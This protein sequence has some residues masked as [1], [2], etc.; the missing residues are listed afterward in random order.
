[1]PEASWCTGNITSCNLFRSG[2]QA[3]LGIALIYQPGMYL[4]ASVFSG[5]T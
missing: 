3:A 5:D 1:M 2:C 4:L